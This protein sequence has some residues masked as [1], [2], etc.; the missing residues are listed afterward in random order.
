MQFTSSSR[1][2]VSAFDTMRTTEITD[3]PPIYERDEGDGATAATFASPRKNIRWTFRY[4]MIFALVLQAGAVQGTSILNFK[5]ELQLFKNSI[6]IECQ[7]P[8]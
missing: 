6:N 2:S 5:C 7:R 3:V 8:Q 4:E 1:R